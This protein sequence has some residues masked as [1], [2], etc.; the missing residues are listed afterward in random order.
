MTIETRAAFA[1]RLDMHK[2]TVTRLQQAGRIV[3]TASGLVDVEASLVLIQET[4]GGRDDVAARHAAQRTTAKAAPGA[5]GGDVAPATSE[6]HPPSAL[7]EASRA[8]AIAESRRVIAQAD[9]EEMERDRLANELIDR[10]DVDAAFKFVGATVRSILD[11]FP[12]QIAPLVAP[13]FDLAEVHALL[14]EACR[15]ALEDFQAAL[16]RQQEALKEEGEV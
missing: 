8:K 5:S 1:R 13:V 10:D 12:D 2:S 16:K 3:L 7:T 14:T 9:K 6:Q 11:V 4:K 15:N